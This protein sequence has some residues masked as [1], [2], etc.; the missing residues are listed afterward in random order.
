MRLRQKQSRNVVNMLK[1]SFRANGE[2]EW[3]CNANTAVDS[4]KKTLL[5]PEI[6]VMIHKG[7]IV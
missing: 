1:S 2:L 6:D 5:K 7:K 4:T 3:L